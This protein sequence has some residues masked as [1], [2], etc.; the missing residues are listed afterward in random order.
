MNCTG[1]AATL[2]TLIEGFSVDLATLLVAAIVSSYTFMGGL[3]TFMGGLG[4]FFYMSYFNSAAIL[5]LIVVFLLK[6]FYDSSPNAS[7]VLGRTT[8]TM[9]ILAHFLALN[10]LLRVQRVFPSLYE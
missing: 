5:I 9:L 6:I 1:G 2:T 3:S 8:H 4:A 10:H 7:N